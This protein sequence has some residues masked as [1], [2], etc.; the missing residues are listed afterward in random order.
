MDV[1]DKLDEAVEAG[2]E[3]LKLVLR[4]LILVFKQLNAIRSLLDGL[5]KSCAR[6]VIAIVGHGES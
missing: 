3:D 1:G 6:V 5:L 4:I 2:V